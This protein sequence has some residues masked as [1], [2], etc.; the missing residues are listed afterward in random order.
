MHF[1][2]LT[3]ILVLVNIYGI[4]HIVRL[5]IL[6]S[7]LKLMAIVFII[8]VGT[9]TVA[10]RRYVP[11]RIHE[12][13]KPLEGHEPSIYSVALALYGVLWAYGAWYVNVDWYYG[14]PCNH[15]HAIFHREVYTNIMHV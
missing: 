8:A 14:H 2:L 7:G 13:F 15:L 4:K 6:F 10:V 11:E 5:S 12:P 1:A 9:I 3:V